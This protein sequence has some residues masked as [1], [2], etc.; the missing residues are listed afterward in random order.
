MNHGFRLHLYSIFQLNQIS[1]FFCGT[2]SFSD[3][4]GIF[5][6]IIQ[7]EYKFIKAHFTS[8]ILR[9]GA[10]GSQEKGTL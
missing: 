5:T 9:E 1:L 8:I 3:I 6:H 4:N 2:S 7:N 10:I